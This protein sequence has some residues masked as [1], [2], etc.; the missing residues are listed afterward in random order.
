MVLLPKKKEA[1]DRKFTR[2]MCICVFC[3]VLFTPEKFFSLQWLS[4]TKC[5]FLSKHK[6]KPVNNRTNT[7]R[8]APWTTNPFTVCLNPGIQRSIVRDLLLFGSIGELFLHQ[9]LNPSFIQIIKIRLLSRCWSVQLLHPRISL[10]WDD[11]QSWK[12][13]KVHPASVVKP[14]I[15]YST[16]AEKRRDRMILRNTNNS[17]SYRPGV[18]NPFS[19]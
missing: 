4:W 7:Q 14:Q 2:H 16:S 12:D 3:D 9:C 8:F 5:L 10:C 19:N 15:R 1:C 18:G 11:S 17:C 6:L 13:G